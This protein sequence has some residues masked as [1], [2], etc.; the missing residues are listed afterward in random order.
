[1]AD[2]DA[3]PTLLFLGDFVDRSPVEM[4][5]IKV[6]DSDGGPF[7]SSFWRGGGERFRKQKR[8]GRP[9]VGRRIRDPN[10]WVLYMLL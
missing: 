6:G 3:R 10:K 7:W 8:E 2:E 4:E 9:Q 1:M 5:G